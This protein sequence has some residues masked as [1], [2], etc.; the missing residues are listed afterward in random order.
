LQ[1]RSPR[2]WS[3]LYLTRC[4]N[5]ISALRED[6]RQII[7]TQLNS[8][9]IT[10]FFIFSCHRRNCYR[11]TWLKRVSNTMYLAA[12]LWESMKGLSA[13]TSSKKSEGS[14]AFKLKVG[15]KFCDINRPSAVWM[16]FIY[17]LILH[18]FLDAFHDVF[19]KYLVKHFKK[20]RIMWPEK[21]NW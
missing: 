3:H 9:A 13:Y 12:E 19:C 18:V 5:A 17:T 2:T 6:W 11:E 1:W 7:L 16:L 14:W 20:V 8:G 4:D 10:F 21:Q 15:H